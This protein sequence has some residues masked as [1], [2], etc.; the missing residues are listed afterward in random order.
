MPLDSMD[1]EDLLQGRAPRKRMGRRKL[2]LI[3]IASLLLI[4]FGLDFLWG[5]TVQTRLEAEIAAIR[6]RGEPIDEKDFQPTQIPD[7]QNAAWYYQQAENAANWVDFKNWDWWTVVQTNDDLAQLSDTLEKNKAALD[8]VGRARDCKVAAWPVTAVDPAT[9]MRSLPELSPQRSLASMI[10]LAAWL[11]ERNG[12]DDQALQSAADILRLSDAVQQYFPCILEN[13]VAT[14]ISALGTETAINLAPRL[15]IVDSIAATRPTGAT[16]QQVLELISLLNDE[17]SFQRGAKLALLGQRRVI[18]DYRDAARKNAGHASLGWLQ[19]PLLDSDSAALLDLYGR[20]A[21]AF[22]QPN[23]PAALK[24][25]PDISGITNPTIGVYVFHSFAHDHAGPLD[26]FVEIYF[27]RLTERRMAAIFLA[28]YLWR[29]D[30]PGQWPI[31]LSELVPKYL[32]A[33]PNDPFSSPGAEI[34]YKPN[35]PAGP[36]IYSVGEDGV[37]D[38]G[39]EEAS[40]PHPGFAALKPDNQWDMKDFV[41]HLIPPP[42]TTRPVAQ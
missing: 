4:L 23:F 13:L 22:D 11:E 12:Q 8:W 26:Q 3:C 1:E 38:G 9:G 28:T 5:W 35:A 18:L 21:T 2:L 42:P 29:A 14:A 27:R 37:D 19:S 31:S 16:R 32:P 10:G 6:A 40:H 30:H 33:V 20:G 34:V 36:I 15:N 24:T 39:S 7:S 25:L 41:Y 17:R